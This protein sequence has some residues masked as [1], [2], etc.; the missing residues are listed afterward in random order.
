M[1]TSVSS[2]HSCAQVDMLPAATVSVWHGI[3]EEE[4][5]EYHPR[6]RYFAIYNRVRWALRS[7]DQTLLAEL[8]DLKHTDVLQRAVVDWRS[9]V[10]QSKAR[11]IHTFL[12]V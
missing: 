11:I 4:F 6:Q 9:L 10:Y 8:A 2:T 1:K 12:Q 5:S 3:I 7:S